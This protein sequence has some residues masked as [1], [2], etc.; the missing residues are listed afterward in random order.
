ME[1]FAIRSTTAP[2]H[3]SLKKRYVYLI[4]VQNADRNG[5]ELFYRN[6]SSRTSH[7]SLHFHVQCG[8]YNQDVYLC[9]NNGSNT[10]TSSDM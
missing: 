1:L 6:Q 2:L 7:L 10:L 8:V 9:R 5:L 4:P 3:H